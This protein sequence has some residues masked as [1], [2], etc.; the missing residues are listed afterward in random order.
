MALCRRKTK[1]LLRFGL[2]L[3]PKNFFQ[4]KGPHFACHITRSANFRQLRRRNITQKKEHSTAVTILKTDAALLEPLK[5]V[6]RVAQTF[7]NNYEEL[8]PFH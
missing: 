6:C 5:Y 8:L 4:P 2:F 7:Q 1:K 3:T